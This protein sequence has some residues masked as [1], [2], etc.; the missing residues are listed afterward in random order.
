MDHI[1]H[2]MGNDQ[3]VTLHHEHSHENYE[4]NMR[5]T[6][7]MYDNSPYLWGEMNA[8]N[9]NHMDT[10]E[11]KTWHMYD[12]EYYEMEN[13]IG[14]SRYPNMENDTAGNITDGEY[15]HKYI[16]GEHIDNNTYDDY[17]GTN[18]THGEYYNM[19]HGEYS[20]WANDTTHEESSSIGNDT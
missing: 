11:N 2:L 7:D 18:M 4:I 6:D 17:M 12:D 20:G 19:T 9:N 3:S 14:G 13:L 5:D 15:E 1:K 8:V 10:D 16:I